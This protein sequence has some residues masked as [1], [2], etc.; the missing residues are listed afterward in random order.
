MKA[1][2]RSG[3][4]ATTAMRWAGRIIGLIAV[5]LFLVFLMER[6][7][8]IPAELT[9]SNPQGIPL[10][11]AMIVAVAGVL[12]AWFL[13]LVGGLMTLIGAASIP[14]L[15]FLGS[16]PTLLLAALILSLP[17]F[18]CGGL[19]VGCCWITRRASVS[20]RV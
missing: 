9:W 19:C 18:V 7:T 3:S 14:V 17:L 1:A 5:G 6:G 4:R 8:R 10:L 15:V 11:L 16:G 2:S 13:E 12:V 20:Q